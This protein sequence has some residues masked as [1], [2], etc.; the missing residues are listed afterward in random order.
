MG[1]LNSIGPFIDYYLKKDEK[2]NFLI[3]TVTLSS[4]NQFK[5]KF[6]GNKRVFHQFLPYDLNLLSNNFLNS[7]KPNVASFVDS[8]I[9]PNFIFNIKKK[10]FH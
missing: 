3:T 5:K 4:Y 8:E 9:W 1:E 6:D 7:W 10:I 2:F